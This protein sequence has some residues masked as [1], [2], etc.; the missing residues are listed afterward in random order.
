[1]TGSDAAC[2]GNH[3]PKELRGELELRARGK[4]FKSPRNLQDLGKG[5][6]IGLTSAF[7]KV[8]PAETWVTG[9]W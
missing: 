4:E 5:E 2:Q 7:P 9:N 6:S 3:I 1:M 8:S